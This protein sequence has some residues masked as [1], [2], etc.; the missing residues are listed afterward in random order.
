[1]QLS[2]QYKTRKFQTTKTVL[3]RQRAQTLHFFPVLEL[4]CSP[5]LNHSRALLMSYVNQMNHEVEN[6]VTTVGGLLMMSWWMMCHKQWWQ[7]WLIIVGF[8]GS[9]SSSHF[10]SWVYWMECCGI[11]AVLSCCWCEFQW[12]GHRYWLSW[13]EN[14]WFGLLSIWLWLVVDMVVMVIYG[15]FVGVVSSKFVGWFKSDFFGYQRKALSNTISVKDQY[16]G[17]FKN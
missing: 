9:S 2:E 13:A 14:R 5:W 3:G 15:V 7:L 11:G 10:N 1:M 8:V 16:F 6:S 17:K 4:I 12:S